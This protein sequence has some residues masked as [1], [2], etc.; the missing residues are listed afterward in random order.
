MLKYCRIYKINRIKKH[1]S[2]TYI[3]VRR[4]FLLL[5]V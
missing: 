4:S 1:E 2:Q 3:A 5:I